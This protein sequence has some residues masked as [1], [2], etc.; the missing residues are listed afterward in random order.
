MRE[1]QGIHNITYRLAVCMITLV[2]LLGG[3]ANAETGCINLIFANG[4]LTVTESLTTYE[5]DVQAYISDGGDVLGEGMV[6]VKYPSEIFGEHAVENAKVTIEKTGILYGK[7]YYIGGELYKLINIT[8]TYPD[9]FSITFSANYYQRTMKPCYTEISN[10]ASEPSDLFHICMIVDQG[11]MGDICFPSEIIG[12]NSLYYDYEYTNFDGGLNI[13]D[14]ML[15]VDTYVAP[16]VEYVFSGIYDMQGFSYKLRQSGVELN[17]SMENEQNIQSYIVERSANGND[18]ETLAKRN[19]KES[20]NESNTYHITD[21]YVVKGMVY[22]YKLTAVDV[23]GCKEELSSKDVLVKSS[24]ILLDNGEFT[25]QSCYPN[26][27]NPS[28]IIPFSVNSTQNVDIRLYD[29]SGKLVKHVADGYYS[30]GNYK[31]RVSCD[32]MTSGVY[33]LITNVNGQKATQKMLLTK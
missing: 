12:M 16:P 25:L 17:W 15:N 23:N 18:F 6:Y 20:N 10:D 9:V 13:A 28:F 27:F 11:A 24:K 2:M 1:R 33:L 5:F 4:E 19:F 22:T 31:I 29:L 30:P 14:A 8:D 3:R 7:D 32:G 26:P 21:R